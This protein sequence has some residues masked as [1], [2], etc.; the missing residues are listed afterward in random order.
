MNMD[1]EEKHSKVMGNRPT[2]SNS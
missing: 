2:N 1:P